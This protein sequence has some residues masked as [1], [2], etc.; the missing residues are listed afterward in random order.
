[1]TI[2]SP[3][4]F[5][6]LLRQ[7]QR[8]SLKP[9]LDQGARAKCERILRR[10]FQL[11]TRLFGADIILGIPNWVLIDTGAWGR[12]NR[13]KTPGGAVLS[14]PHAGGH[15]LATRTPRGGPDPSGERHVI[16]QPSFVR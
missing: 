2:T 6:S 14:C 4:G 5:N 7:S 9:R 10:D 8:Q 12:S 16:G 3:L 15:A 1:M 11:Q 13:C